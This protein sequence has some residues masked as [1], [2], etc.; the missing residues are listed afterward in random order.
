MSVDPNLYVCSEK[1]ELSIFPF[2]H[3][4]HIEFKS[5]IFGDGLSPCTICS[6]DCLDGMDCLQCDVCDEWFHTECRYGRFAGDN[7]GFTA[8]E[9]IV[10]NNYEAI[11]SER[12][13]MQLMPFSGFRYGTLVKTDIFMPQTNKAASF[14]K[15]LAK[16]NLDLASKTHPNE[17]VKLDKFLDI[18]C[19]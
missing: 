5:T 18:N 1:C 12:C 10:D 4:D 3:L 11:C 2:T 7:D 19:S 13:Y 16:P 14:R 17:F 8:H 6:Y 15:F 9:V